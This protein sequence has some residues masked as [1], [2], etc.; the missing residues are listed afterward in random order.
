VTAKLETRGGELTADAIKGAVLGLIA[1]SGVYPS[2]VLDFAADK[3]LDPRITFSRASV[4][5]YF[6][7]AGTML[8]AANNLP[9]FDHD[10]ISRKSL[11]LL[12][13]E[14]RTNLLLNSAALVTQNITVTAA[15]HTL[16]FW[17]TGTVTLS[18]ASTAG[19]LV[20]TGASNRVS[21][22]F[23]PSA[24]TLTLTV[25]GTVT[26]AQCEVGAFAT[27]YIPTLGATATRA[28][29]SA[30]MTGGNFTSWFRQDVGAFLASGSIPVNTSA[31]SSNRCAL[32]AS[33]STTDRH[34]L[35]LINASNTAAV[36]FLMTASAT[37]VN[38]AL[39]PT[40]PAGTRRSMSYA[41]ETNNVNAAVDGTLGTVDTSCTIPTNINTLVIGGISSSNAVLNGHLARLVYWPARLP[42]A[43]LLALTNA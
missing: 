31:A 24:G 16:T 41:Y 28:A 42:N 37:Q 39:G 35:S 8:T 29:D 11:G 38:A 19:P 4:G 3:T 12:L 9:R 17:G 22:S 7:A 34:T 1:P 2:L 27:S 5:T 43:D 25:T 13:E 14:A 15:A 32:S 36:Y 23:T 6:D 33:A 20:G 18:G 30:Q 21:L 40:L 26:N 10:P